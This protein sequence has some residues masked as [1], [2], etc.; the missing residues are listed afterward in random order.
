MPHPALARERWRALL[1]RAVACCALLLAAL[2][3]LPAAA[4]AE[5]ATLSTGAGKTCAVTTSADVTCWGAYTAV[6]GPP[7]PPGPG[8][9]TPEPTTVPAAA[10][11]KTVDA[12]EQGYQC[13]VRTDGSIGCWG[14]AWYFDQDYWPTRNVAPVGLVKTGVSG[15]AITN[16]ADVAVN[17]REGCAVQSTGRVRCWQAGAE[18]INDEI[19]GITDATAVTS[20]GEAFCAVRATGGVACWDRGLSRTTGIMMGPVAVWTKGATATNVPG[21]AGAVSASGTCAVL[22]DGK[23]TCWTIS[24]R[25]KK[26]EE[27]VSFTTPTVVEGTGKVWRM[28]SRPGNNC[29]VRIDTKV[30]CWGSGAPAVVDGV[31]LATDVSVGDGFACARDADAKVLCWGAGKYLGNAAVADLPQ[32]PPATPTG[33]PQVAGSIGPRPE[34]YPLAPSRPLPSTN[35]GGFGEV[36]ATAI[37]VRWDAPLNVPESGLKGYE[38]TLGGQTKSV[39][40]TGD[41]TQFTGLT[42]S[43]SYTANVIAIDNDGGRSEPL[44]IQYTTLADLKIG[45][46]AFEDPDIAGAE[47]TIHW[48]PTGSL[49]PVSFLLEVNNQQISLPG[50]ARSYTITGLAGSTNYLIRL[51]ARD[52]EGQQQATSEVTYRT[53]PNTLPTPSPSPTPVPT[54]VPVIAERVFTAKGTTT[55]ATLTKSPMPVTGRVSVMVNDLSEIVGAGSITLNDTQG[56]STALGFLP[57]T[58]TIGFATSQV[59]LSQ[60]SPLALSYKLRVKVKSVK[61]FGA[62]PLAGGN[63]CQTKQLTTIPLASTAGGFSVASGGTLAGNY[64]ISDLNGCGLFGGLVTPLVASTGNPMSLTL[65]P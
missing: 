22:D 41:A 61:A 4:Q 12:G 58:A 48:H 55:I 46:P 11:A 35:G 33:N 24:H 47:I 54:R 26:D 16:F 17:D 38:V 28:A 59:T 56:R 8:I 10:P 25:P 40:P 60:A 45:P 63:N 15:T 18:A 9:F 20:A 51:T 32:S 5:F 6:G 19:A 37:I 31:D 42:P 1:S 39:P 44:V 29:A 43:T 7:P 64:A 65:T 53:E 30:V 34:L 36:T 62:I 23:V 27:Y 21:I 2:T 49:A 14:W 50:S 57:V 3:A 13:A 52:G